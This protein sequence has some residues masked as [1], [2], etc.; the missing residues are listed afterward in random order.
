MSTETQCDDVTVQWDYQ[1][2]GTDDVIMGVDAHDV[3]VYGPYDEDP[4][5][6]SDKW[7]IVSVKHVRKSELENFQNFKSYTNLNWFWLS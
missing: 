2:S 7:K 1:S 5:E 6:D 4:T 3:T